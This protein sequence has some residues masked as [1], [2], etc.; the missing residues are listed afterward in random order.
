MIERVGFGLDP[1]EVPIWD[2]VSYHFIEVCEPCRAEK[3][4]QIARD[5]RWL[6][7]RGMGGVSMT[8]T[9]SWSKSLIKATTEPPFDV[10]S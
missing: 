3:S 2:D 10:A 7:V 5:V 1:A 4:E 9:D 6:H 8:Y